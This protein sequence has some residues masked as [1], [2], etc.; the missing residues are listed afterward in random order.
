LLLEIL[1]D[2]G[3]RLPYLSRGIVHALREVH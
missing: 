2:F 1:N 3:F